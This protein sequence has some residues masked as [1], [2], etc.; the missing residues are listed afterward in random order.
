MRWTARGRRPSVAPVYSTA[1]AVRVAATPAVANGP[2]R[3]VGR[4]STVGITLALPT[5]PPAS[6]YTCIPA[7]P[8]R[9]AVPTSPTARRVRHMS[10]RAIRSRAHL[11]VDVAN[12]VEQPPEVVE[13]AVE[14]AVGSPCSWA[15][16]VVMPASR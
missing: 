16:S 8:A 13:L 15:R 6:Q 2:G 4:P 5:R 10:N 12:E 9:V 3:N 7:A 1:A 14:V 11:S